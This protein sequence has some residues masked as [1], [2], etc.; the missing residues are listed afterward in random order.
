MVSGVNFTPIKV[1]ADD[2]C[3]ICLSESDETMLGHDNLHPAHESC[4]RSWFQK[5]A[6][7]P[8]CRA[9]VANADRFFW[10]EKF[11]SEIEGMSQTL[12]TT[13][14][15]II[16]LAL[17]FI[18]GA[19]YAFVTIHESLLLFT[20]ADRVSLVASIALQ[21][22]LIGA[23]VAALAEMRSSWSKL[24][25]EWAGGE[26]NSSWFWS[27][28]LRI[29]MVATLWLYTLLLLEEL[30]GL[31]V[32]LAGVLSYLAYEAT[33]SLEIPRFSEN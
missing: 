10:K 17:S 23:K 31:S 22:L 3:S 29:N 24:K 13:A 5:K 9:E 25:V 26:N 33:A 20:I 1:T 11:I 14:L 4:L 6:T 2:T 16:F 30:E 21:A 18:G 28:A 32:L 19:L 15:V 12:K 7:C 27:G 8:M